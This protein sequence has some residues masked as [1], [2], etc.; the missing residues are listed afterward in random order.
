MAAETIP[1]G[2]DVLDEAIGYPEEGQAV[3]TAADEVVNDD[4]DDEEDDD[5]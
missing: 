4:Y 2:F 3:E 5:E 1:A